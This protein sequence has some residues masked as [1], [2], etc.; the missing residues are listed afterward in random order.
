MISFLSPGL[1]PI[2]G[3]ELPEGACVCAG[4]RSQLEAERIDGA[5]RCPVCFYPLTGEGCPFC[6]SRNLFFERHV[7]LYR[8]SDPW[9]S[10]LNHWKFQNE[11]GLHR[12]F[13]DALYSAFER[14][15]SFDRI[16]YISSG[17]FGYD[18]RSYSPCRDLCSQVSRE[19]GIP[20]GADIVKIARGRQSGRGVVER[21]LK[22]RDAF[23]CTMPLSGVER[24]L[25]IEDI[26]T[27]GATA[28]EAARIVRRN[29]AGGVSILS[30]LMRENI[31]C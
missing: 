18:V 11:R 8:L 3:R 10:L 7:S 26:F 31:E 20:F 1:C 5:G 13:N 4:C 30:M 12:I 22:I 19:M 15:G 29:G 2:C 6:E 9:R 23:S 27:T 14:L 28:N 16:I 17:R 25:L 24:I 21:F